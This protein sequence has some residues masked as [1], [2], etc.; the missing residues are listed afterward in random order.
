MVG[1][2]CVDL[3]AEWRPVRRNQLPARYSAHW[4]CAGAVGQW[5]SFRVEGRE[6]RAAL[7]D[8]EFDLLT[9]QSGRGTELRQLV[10]TDDCRCEDAQ[11][12]AITRHST[13]HIDRQQRVRL[14]GDDPK[15]VH[16]VEERVHASAHSDVE[17]QRRS[18]TGVG[19]FHG[20]AATE[21]ATLPKVGKDRRVVVPQR[22]VMQQISDLRRCHT[23]DVEEHGVG[24]TGLVDT[25]HRTH[26]ILDNLQQT[27]RLVAGLDG[28][29]QRVAY[30]LLR[31]GNEDRER[32]QHP[33]R[34]AHL[35]HQGYIPVQ[36]PGRSR[37][38]QA[39]SLELDRKQD[40]I[41]FRRVAA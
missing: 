26:L 31:R 33:S 5:H 7:V 40:L 22:C 18:A 27:Q 37:A 25:R 34:I 21:A 4:H 32:Q 38:W 3:H 24:A 23:E 13:A 29:R 35:P 10:I 8:V 2:F 9:A 12:F 16:Q 30:P 15:A 14:H 20:I 1:T 39:T 19:I 6:V 36:V 17:H 11:P 41:R 28:L